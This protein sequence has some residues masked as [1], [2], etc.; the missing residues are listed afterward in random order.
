MSIVKLTNCLG[1]QLFEMLRL[2]P[3]RNNKRLAEILRKYRIDVQVGG[4]KM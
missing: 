1:L 2:D 4:C 3:K